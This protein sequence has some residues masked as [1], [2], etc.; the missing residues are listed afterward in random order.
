MRFL[1]AEQK[2]KQ[3]MQI[4]LSVITLRTI[5]SQDLNTHELA[6]SLFRVMHLL[7]HPLHVQMS[8][9]GLLLDV[10]YVHMSLDILFP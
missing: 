6:H 4:V 1:L 10:G 3:K 7:K 9:P 2:R 5:V 8:A